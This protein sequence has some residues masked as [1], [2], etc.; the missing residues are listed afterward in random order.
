MAITAIC[1]SVELDKAQLPGETIYLLL[2]FLSVHTFVHVTLSVV[3]Y[4]EIPLNPE[5]KLTDPTKA[6]KYDL[7]MGLEWKAFRHNKIDPF[8]VSS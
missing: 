3:L 5:Y 6:P 8:S 1:F 7:T 2:A 4:S